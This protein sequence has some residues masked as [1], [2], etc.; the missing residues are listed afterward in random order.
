[1]PDRGSS[2]Q[3]DDR[4]LA[5][6]V[7]GASLIAATFGL[8][9][10]GYGLLLP[11][12]RADLGINATTA[13]A[14]S[15]L[16]YGT[17]F[18][19]NLAVVR[20]IERAGVRAALAMATVTATTGMGL[21][22]CA[23]GTLILAIG[24]AFAGA[25]SGFAF[26]PYAEIVH[27][28]LSQRHRATVWAIVSSGT[29]WGVAVAAPIALLAGD[30]WRWAW[31][32]FVIIALVVGALAHRAAPSGTP[33]PGAG[34]P[35]SMRQMLR[36]PG[37]RPLLASAMAVGAGSSV[38]W[39]FSVDSLR[40]DGVGSTSA[41]WIYAACGIASLMASF[42][43]FLVGRYGLRSVNRVAAALVAITL[44]TFGV[45]TD[46]PAAA[47]AASFVFGAAYTTVIAT[48][49]L[50]SAAIFVN[51]QSAGLAAMNAALTIGTL[52]GPAIAGAVIDI[53][54]H[55]TAFAVASAATLPALLLRPPSEV[56]LKASP[57]NRTIR[58][59]E[60]TERC[61]D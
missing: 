49:G 40:Q 23:P 41:R 33:S 44:V 53:G 3:A 51:R 48:Q 14:I 5:T 38:W 60:R 9:R 61:A 26:P 19:A 37:A 7:A 30:R 6:A 54:T 42:T 59:H 57:R 20:L 4:W 11:D 21:I 58:S 31:G 2:A 10:Y 8:A 43:G 36:R 47:L 22:A 13:G 55:A 17:Y 45:A 1:M 46:R 29:G 15:S 25:S 12:M 39:S 27:R 24:V 32:C 52:V 34:S 56:S 16:S 35:A 28:G 50:W 18:V